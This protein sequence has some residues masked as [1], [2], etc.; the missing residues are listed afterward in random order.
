MSPTEGQ[1]QEFQKAILAIKY[2]MDFSL[3]VYYWSHTDSTINYI[4]IYLQKFHE[5][6]DVFLH[7][8]VKQRTQDRANKMSKDHT[9]QF[10]SQKLLNTLFIA[11]Q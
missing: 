8:R 7:Y 5:Y 2:L 11:A 1:K 4:S 10:T 6:K 3:L 9:I